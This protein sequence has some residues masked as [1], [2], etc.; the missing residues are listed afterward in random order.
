M[1]LTYELLENIIVTA[2]EGGSNYWATVD[3]FPEEPAGEPATIKLATALWND[4]DFAVAIWDSEN[5]TEKLGTLT[6]EGIRKALKLAQED[7]GY[8]WVIAQLW[9]DEWDAETTDVIMQL[10]VM[11]EVVYG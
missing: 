3:H 9:A 11:G 6:L 10:A 2:L 1:K 7:T 5:P 4:K 8:H